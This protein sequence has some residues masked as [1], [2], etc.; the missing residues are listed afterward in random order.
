MEGNK[1]AVNCQCVP[2]HEHMGFPL[3]LF[4]SE[5]T[6]SVDPMIVERVMVV[7]IFKPSAFD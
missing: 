7:G 3:P 2:W 6:F 5:E 4:V 1:R